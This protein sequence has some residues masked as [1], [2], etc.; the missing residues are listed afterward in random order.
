MVR[1]IKLVTNTRERPTSFS[2]VH[3]Y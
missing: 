3:V 1:K 2:N